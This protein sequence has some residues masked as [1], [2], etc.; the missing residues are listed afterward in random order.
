MPIPER[1]GPSCSA[2]NTLSEIETVKQTTRR[3]H[4]FGRTAFFAVF[5]VVSFGC[6]EDTPKPPAENNVSSEES[7]VAAP[8]PGPVNF[9]RGFDYASVPGATLVTVRGPVRSWTKGGEPVQKEMQLVLEEQG[10]SAAA[11]PSEWQGAVRVRVPVLRIAVNSQAEEAFLSE[12][13]V[14]GRLVAVGGLKSYDAQIRTRVEKGE[15]RQVGYSWHSP[16]NMDVVV[17]L[18]P[19]VFVMR[20]ADLDHAPSMDRLLE[21]GIPTIPYFIDAEDT[22]L[23]RA[24]WI[25]FFGLLTGQLEVADRVFS[26]IQA[27]TE[28]IRAEAS[29]LASVPAMWAYPVGRDRWYAFVRGVEAELLEDAGGENLLRRPDD[30]RQDPGIE[31][32]TE[33]IADRGRNA[34]VWII[35][36]IHAAEIPAFSGLADIPAYRDGQLYSND[37]RS[38]P[39]KDAYDLYELGFIRP[40]LLMRDL[41]AIL[42][43]P[44]EL[45]PDAYFR[46]VK[47]SSNTP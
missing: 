14:K 9:A 8:I 20:L 46:S 4:C 17:A 24:E 29:R 1:P 38:I 39:E 28:A 37:G 35:G 43:E 27:R 22:Y 33:V 47:D 23:G 30:A 12:L 34:V 32:A 16:P 10:F 36:D 25:R 26:G 42:H 5:L 13:G 18:D 15:I 2:S 11:L 45:S 31:I 3:T 6:T 44:G 40:D 7:A 21:L 41:F 19:D